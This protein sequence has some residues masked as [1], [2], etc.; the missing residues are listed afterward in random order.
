MSESV[1]E[2]VAR[3]ER[4]LSK[5][6]LLIEA[7]GIPPLVASWRERGEALKI[8][9][10]WIDGWDPNFIYDEAWPADRDRAR[11]A[12]AGSSAPPVDAIAARRKPTG[13]DELCEECPD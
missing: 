13:P 5:N 1:E 11:A 9:F 4:K 7:D 3:I 8:L 10:E 12:L 2:I 6:W